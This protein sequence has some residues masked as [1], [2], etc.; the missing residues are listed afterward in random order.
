MAYREDAGELRSWEGDKQ[1]NS[2]LKARKGI[3]F[4]PQS[5]NHRINQS[6]TTDSTMITI[7]TNPTIKTIK[8][9]QTKAMSGGKS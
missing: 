5:T 9:I 3:I 7:L 8:T 6:T 1:S 2:R 4:F